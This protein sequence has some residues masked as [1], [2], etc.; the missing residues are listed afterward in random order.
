MNKSIVGFFDN[1]QQA[2]SARL[3]LLSE[4]IT[5]NNIQLFSGDSTRSG[6]MSSDVSVSGSGATSRDSY[7]NNDNE[8]FTDRIKHFFTSMSDQGAGDDADN[9]AE[10]IRRGGTTLL[11]RTDD[12]MIDT[13]SDILESNGAVDINQRGQYYKESGFQNFDM[14]SGPLSEEQRLSSQSQYQDW[15]KNRGGEQ[16]LPVI[17]EKVNV[18]KRQIENGRVR[19]YTRVSET[20][21]DEDIQ[22]RDER[23]EVER[24]PVDRPIQSSDMAA[25]QEGEIE[26]RETSEEAVVNKEARVVEEVRVRRQAEER[27]EHIHETA[28][29]TD[30]EVDRNR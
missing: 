22:L 14:N 25:F 24:N 15:E 9:Y 1:R 12:P 29:R 17:E 28:R 6:S 16:V 19:I 21:I 10:G 7:T 3:E 30:I 2:E 13:V 8:S 23:V 4:G 27:T 26:L 11:V 20:P 5:D 18:S